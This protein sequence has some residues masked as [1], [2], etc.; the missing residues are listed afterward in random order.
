[1]K[2]ETFQQR[3]VPV[4]NKRGPEGSRE[5]NINY[6]NVTK[7]PSQTFGAANHVVSKKSEGYFKSA[8]YTD[9]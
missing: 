1:M 7:S 5:R 2:E 9:I 8:K 3:V 6:A 4:K